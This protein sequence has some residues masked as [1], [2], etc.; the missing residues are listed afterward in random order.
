MLSHARDSVIQSLT[1]CKYIYLAAKMSQVLYN[2]ICV[3]FKS[4]LK[5]SSKFQSNR[6][7]FSQ[8]RELEYLAGD[9]SCTVYLQVHLC[10]YVKRPFSTQDH[11]IPYSRY[12]NLKTWRA[13]RDR[14]T[15]LSVFFRYAILLFSIYICRNAKF[16]I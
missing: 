7:A 8:K 15:P 12:P 3:I 1:M 10:M 4:I 5:L 16:S 2:I 11:Y 13:R 9:G 6:K 14:N